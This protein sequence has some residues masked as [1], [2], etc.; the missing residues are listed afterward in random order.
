MTRVLLIE[1]DGALRRALAEALGIYGFTVR[2]VGRLDEAIRVLAEEPID[3]VVSD[4]RLEGSTGT[5]LDHSLPAPVIIISGQ[6]SLAMR[7]E[8]LE[9]GAFEVLAKPVSG[10]ELRCV[11]ES[12]VELV[13]VS[14]SDRP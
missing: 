6:T 7:E 14:T 8:N 9:H 11:I 5:I 3:V 12:A 13:E 2:A 10:S 1:D 4:L